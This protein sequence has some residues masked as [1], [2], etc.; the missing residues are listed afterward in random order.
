MIEV[1]TT[2]SY[3]QDGNEALTT[4]LREITK[5]I[6]EMSNAVKSSDLHVISKSVSD[7]ALCVYRMLNEK[8]R[9]KEE[10]AALRANLGRWGAKEQ[11]ASKAALIL[12]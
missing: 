12:N 6:T 10:L 4:D 9:E 5:K 3:L 11:R 8:K 7:L 2:T 1:Q